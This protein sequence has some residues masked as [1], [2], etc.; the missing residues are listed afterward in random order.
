MVVL[1]QKIC[2]KAKTKM[3]SSSVL[4]HIFEL[5]GPLFSLQSFYRKSLVYGVNLSIKN[6]YNLAY[7]CIANTLDIFYCI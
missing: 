5:C 3:F 1:P 4:R 2:V 7:I 6:Y